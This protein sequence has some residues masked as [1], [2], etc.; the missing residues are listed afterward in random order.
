MPADGIQG[1]R[2][3]CK[4]PYVLA[5]VRDLPCFPGVGSVS[6]ILHIDRNTT[7]T[8]AV[9]KVNGH[10]IRVGRKL[11]LADNAGGFIQVRKSRK[12]VFSLEEPAS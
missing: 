1:I 2:R 9:G 12:L 8:D 7:V 5:P 6:M 10:S 11:Q 3:Q 4:G